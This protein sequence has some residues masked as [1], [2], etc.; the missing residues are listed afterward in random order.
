[1][2]FNPVSIKKDIILEI[3]LV[4]EQPI[5]HTSPLN[6]NYYIKSGQVIKTN[7]KLVILQSKC[8]QYGNCWILVALPIKARKLQSITVCWSS[9]NNSHA[10]TYSSYNNA[11]VIMIDSET[12]KNN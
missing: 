6:L 9:K 11:F 8:F 1:M 10:C 5:L 4:W 7:R 12:I 3:R 2:Q